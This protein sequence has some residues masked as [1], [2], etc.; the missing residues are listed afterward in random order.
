MAIT[1]A[2][3]AAKLETEIKGVFGNPEDP[4]RLT[5]FCQ[6]VAKAVVDEIKTNAEVNPG[7]LTA[8]QNAGPVTGK[9]TI[10]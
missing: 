7:T 9:G 5:S 3:L 2:S 10:S 4:A 8:P 6:A 1:S